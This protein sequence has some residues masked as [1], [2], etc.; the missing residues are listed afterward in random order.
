MISLLQSNNASDL[1]DQLGNLSEDVWTLA[2][3][4]SVVITL[5]L[6]L[7]FDLLFKKNKEVGLAAIAFCG[8]AS[9][10]VVLAFQWTQ[11]STDLMVMGDLLRYDQLATF[12]KLA[13]TIGAALG[14]VIATRSGERN[15]LFRAGESLVILFGLLLGV[16]LMTMA[17]NLLMIYL[18]I[19]VVSICSYMLTGILKGKKKAEAALK[20]LLFGAVSSAVM[21][22]GI[23]WLYGFTGT[24]DI[25][26]L[27]FMSGLAEVPALPLTIAL[28]MTLG[29]I[30]FKLGAVPFHIWSPDVYEAA[31]TA[32]VSVFSTLPKLAALVILFRVVNTLP[33]DLFDWQL[34]LGI[35]AIASMTFGN[36]SALWQKDAKRMLAYSSIAHAGFLLVA[37]IAYTEAGN[38]AMLFYG[39]MYLV[40]NFAAFLL[41][42]M[43]EKRAGSAAFDSLR[44]LGTTIPFLGVLVVVVMIALT[45]LPPTVGFNAKLYIFSA[46]WESYEA[47]NN[48]ILLWVFIIGLLNTVVALFYYL[49]LPYFLFF[50]TAERAVLEKS[51]AVDH[52]WGTIMV[53]PLLLWF[54]QSE[55]LMDILNSINFVF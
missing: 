55:W 25:T 29:G 12:L 7:G 32:I 19:E 40:M 53:L 16:F 8:L 15:D 17:A 33:A 5:L 38:T 39:A 35:I 52:I 37:L 44:G 36:F 54:F 43:L 13:F 9:T 22:Y 27:A 14:L 11:W 49:R 50:K 21:L 30:I 4:I 28:I 3:E 18:S 26:S 31:P 47:Q 1:K 20:Y 24:L 42:A 46:I 2:P 45:G 23:S 48:S 10:F 41:I 34:I 51:S 6:L